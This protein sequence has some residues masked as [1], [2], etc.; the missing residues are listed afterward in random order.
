MDKFF[1]QYP[2]SNLSA[3]QRIYHEDPHIALVSAKQ[4][5]TVEYID[6]PTPFMRAA[7]KC[8]AQPMHLDPSA[9]A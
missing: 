2:G 8:A 4:T 5:T 9:F 3:A 6:Y 7:H 1:R